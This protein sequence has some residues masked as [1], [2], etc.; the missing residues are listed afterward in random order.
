VARSRDHVRELSRRM[1]GELMRLGLVDA[2]QTVPLAQPLCT[3]DWAVTAP[4]R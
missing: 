3:A 2:G 4:L 1:R